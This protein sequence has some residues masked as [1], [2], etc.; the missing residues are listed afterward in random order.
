M[1]RTGSY[2]VIQTCYKCNLLYPCYLYGNVTPT[3]GIAT[4]HVCLPLC[5]YTDTRLVHE[6]DSIYPHSSFF[7]YITFHAVFVFFTNFP[8]SIL[9]SLLMKFHVRKADCLLSRSPLIILTYISV[10]LFSRY[11][12]FYALWNIPWHRF[13]IILLIFLTKLCH[14][15]SLK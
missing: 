2:D 1:N 3:T 13:D 15:L 9:Q 14:Y 6:S 7:L 12:S 5:L 11:S 4:V 8:D 10:I